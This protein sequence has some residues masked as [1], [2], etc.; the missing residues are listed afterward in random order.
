MTNMDMKCALTFDQITDLARQYVEQEPFDKNMGREN[1]ALSAGKRI[2]EGDYSLENL[3]P[4][5]DW[6]SSRPKRLVSANDPSDLADA[7]ATMISCKRD[8]T[9]VATLIGLRGVQVPM[10]SAILTAYDPESY[11][12]IDIR[13]LQTLGVKQASPSIDH[14]LKYLSFCRAEATS[15]RVPLRNLDRA[16]WQASKNL[17]IPVSN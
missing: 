14:Y 11:T 7:L 17:G 2:A 5:V 1:K 13:A 15:K 10:A 16:L 4:I 3:M 8:R 12:I 9:K 6:K